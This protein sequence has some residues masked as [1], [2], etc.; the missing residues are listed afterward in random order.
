MTEIIPRLWLGDKRDALAIIKHAKEVAA[1]SVPD[2]CPTRTL[3]AGVDP[4][5]SHATPMPPPHA[6]VG[7][8][9]TR[10]NTA[11]TITAADHGSH[12]GRV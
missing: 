9:A 7:H 8:Q 6:L 2:G 10:A 1:G 12:R 11:A 4:R 3:H 5:P